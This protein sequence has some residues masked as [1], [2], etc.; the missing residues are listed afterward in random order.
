MVGL[1][2]VYFLHSQSRLLKI[3]IVEVNRLNVFG[4]STPLYAVISPLHEIGIHKTENILDARC[5]AYAFDI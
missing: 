2:R 1:D 5:V 3:T 4:P